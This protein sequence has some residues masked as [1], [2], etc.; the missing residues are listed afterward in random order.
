[1]HSVSVV[2]SLQPKPLQ[3]FCPL[4]ELCAVL[5]ALVPLQEFPPLH[6][7]FAPGERGGVDCFLYEGPPRMFCQGVPA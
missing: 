5:Q 4:H 1:M 7:T 2:V 3:E 6:F